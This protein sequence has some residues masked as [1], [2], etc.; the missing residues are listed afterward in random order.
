MEKGSG[1]LSVKA[2]DPFGPADFV[3]DCSLS[4]MRHLSCRGAARPEGL[5][6]NSPR[7]TPWVDS[8]NI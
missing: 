8:G 6:R 5:K 3:I 1:T 7:A 4:D 2:P